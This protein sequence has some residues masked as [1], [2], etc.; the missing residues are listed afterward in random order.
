MCSPWGDSFGDRSPNWAG[1]QRTFVLPYGGSRVR[2]ASYDDLASKLL[3]RGLVLDHLQAVEGM[4]LVDVV[5]A[6]FASLPAEVW[7]VHKGFGALAEVGRGARYLRLKRCGTLSRMN[8]MQPLFAIQV[9]DRLEHVLPDVGTAEYEAL[10]PG[11]PAWSFAEEQDGATFTEPLPGGLQ[12][13]Q[14]T[15]KATVAAAKHELHA[16]GNKRIAYAKFWVGNRAASGKTSHSA[17]RQQVA[18]RPD[19]VVPLATKQVDVLVS[20]LTPYALNELSPD[21]TTWLRKD[22]PAVSH[23]DALESLRRAGYAVFQ[24]HYL[25]DLGVRTVNE[26]PVT[27]GLH[28]FGGRRRSRRSRRSRK[29]RRSRRAAT[30]KRQR[31]NGR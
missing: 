14:A 19:W 9:T 18:L 1:M 13:G 2:A 27:T 10:K 30:P 23:E 17:S 22:L 6:T 26:P 25:G 4:Q 12:R 11:T 5:P 24:Q 21:G 3:S 29:S 28:Y 16:D 8:P 7:M 31:G 20:G 15:T